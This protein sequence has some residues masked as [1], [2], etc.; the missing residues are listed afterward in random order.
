VTFFSSTAEEGVPAL[1]YHWDFGDGIQVDG[2][3]VTHTYTKSGNYT[4]RLTSEGVDGLIAEKTF[5]V[6]VDGLMEIGPPRRYSET[7]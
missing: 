7:Q 4:V 1:A 5:S 6:T 2:A 3:S